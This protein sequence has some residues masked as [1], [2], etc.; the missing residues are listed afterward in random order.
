MRYLVPSTHMI[1]VKVSQRLLGEQK[2]WTSSEHY[3]SSVDR[4]AARVAVTR[5]LGLI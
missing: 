5:Y 3:S 2:V 1:M 4:P